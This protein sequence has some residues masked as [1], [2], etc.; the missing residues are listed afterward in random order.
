MKQVV[1][2][3][4][5]H[6]S[7]ASDSDA[8]H[9]FFPKTAIT[10]CKYQAAKLNGTNYTDKPGLPI[11]IRNKI[12]PTFMELS[13]ETLLEKCLHGSTQNNNECIIG[14]TW[15]RIPKDVLVGRIVLEIGVRSVVFSFNGG[16]IGLSKILEKHSMVTGSFAEEF[17]ASRDEYLIQK[18]DI[19]SSGKAIV[20]RGKKKGAIRAIR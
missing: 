19:K 14:D 6:C 16:A 12:L 20:Q 15:K 4:V 11:I 5:Y 8:R 9:I 7:Q 3:V 18:A 10:W 1:G 13:D 2:A 17:C